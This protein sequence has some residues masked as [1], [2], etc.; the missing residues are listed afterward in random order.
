[1]LHKNFLQL[2]TIV[3]I[4]L[5]TLTNSTAQ[6][7][8]TK[9]KGKFY[10]QVG[11][12]FLTYNQLLNGETSTKSWTKLNADFTD[13]TVQAYGEYG[14]TNRIM[15]SAQLPFRLLSSKNV[16]QPATIS[17]GSLTALG[18]VHAAVTANF[19]N[20]DGIVLSGKANVGLPTSKF[21]TKTGLRSGFDAT[22]IEP[23]LLFGYGHAKF[24]ASGEAGYVIRNNNYSNRVH[25]AGQIGKFFGKSKKLMASLNVE[26]M[27]SGSDGTYDD[28][29]S[30]KT[31]LYLDE[32][33][34]L[35]PTVKLG[36]KANPKVTLW[37]SAG[38][39]LAPI[40]KNI[41]ASP[42]LSFSVS[43]QN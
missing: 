31:G 22:S 23:S 33:S 21:D 10:A 13:M 41:A 26:L 27:K 32:Q 35:S 6:Q 42:G 15:L 3:F 11:G 7:A 24:F 20:K 4:T 40:T 38:G 25:V 43:Y 16:V 8:W 2:F 29:T 30:A 5:L 34:Y 19:Y 37:L 39:G 17:E 14:I 28:G 18:N 1:M 12:S 36:Y 9:E